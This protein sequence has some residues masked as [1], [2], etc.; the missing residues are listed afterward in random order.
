MTKQKRLSPDTKQCL[1]LWT[2]QSSSFYKLPSYSVVEY[3]TQSQM[4]RQMGNEAGGAILQIWLSPFH[5]PST[6]SMV[7]C[8]LLGT[9]LFSKWASAP[10]MLPSTLPTPLLSAMLS[11]A[12][13]CCLGSSFYKSPQ[14]QLSSSLKRSY[15]ALNSQDKCEWL[16]LHPRCVQTNQ[17][18]SYYDGFWLLSFVQPDA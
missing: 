4:E 2:K 7:P 13:T 9:H 3:R 8:K 15:K 14:L 17:I 18:P 16:F 11:P 10:D 12:F 6:R 1:T 5:F